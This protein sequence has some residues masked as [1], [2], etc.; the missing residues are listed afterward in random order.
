MH[1]SLLPLVVLLAGASCITACTTRTIISAAAA[2]GGADEPDEAPATADDSGDGNSVVETSSSSGAPAK[3]DAGKPPP[4]PP[5]QKDAGADSSSSSGGPVQTGGSITLT[6]PSSGFH[7]NPPIE[8]ASVPKTLL[9]RCSSTTKACWL[10]ASTNAQID[11]CLAADTTP[12]AMLDG[13]PL[14]CA[15]CERAQGAYCMASACPS[16][17]GAYGC[18]AQSKGDAACSADLASVTACAGSTGKAKFVSCLGGLVTQC[19]P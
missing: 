14:D 5:A 12:P 4:P 16:Q 13:E 17:F 19:F 7:Q 2:D 9:P 1:R 3:A 8:I 11:A 6:C 10:A 15:G 18:C